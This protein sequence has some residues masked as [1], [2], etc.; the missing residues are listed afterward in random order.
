MTARDLAIA[1]LWAVTDRPY[2]KPLLPIHLLQ[3]TSD[4]LVVGIHDN[5]GPFSK[6]ILCCSSDGRR[7]RG[8]TGTRCCPD[9]DE[10][11]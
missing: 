7:V 6:C 1:R 2:R 8:R 9:S 5:A 11:F 4:T 3:S 10:E